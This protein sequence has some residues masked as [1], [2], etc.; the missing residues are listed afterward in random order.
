MR[1]IRYLVLILPLIS[2]KTVTIYQTNI[3]TIQELQTELQTTL[4]T[5]WTT[6]T[7]SQD[8]TSTTSTTTITRTRTTTIT[9]GSTSFPSQ[10]VALHNE[11][12]SLHSAQPLTWSQNLTTY[13]QSY[14]DSYNCNGTLIHSHGSYGEN[15]ALGYNTSAGIQAWYDEVSL[16]DYNDAG[17]SESTGHFTQLVWNS[18]RSVGCAVKDCGSYYGQYLVCEYDPPGNIAGQ[19]DDNVFAS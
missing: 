6:R 1:L 2:A 10:V 4:I 17:F 8:S 7:L 15:L 19:Y 18:T 5:R 3:H 14:A 9:S 13:A 11:K 12:R 16:Y